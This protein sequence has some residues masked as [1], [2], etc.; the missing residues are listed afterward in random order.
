MDK[1]ESELRTSVQNKVKLDLYNAIKC[2][3]GAEKYLL[4]NIDKY[5]KSLLSQLRY[6]IF[7][8]QIET[9][10][11]TNEHREERVCTLCASNTIESVEHFLFECEAYALN[12]LVTMHCSS[13]K[14]PKLGIGIFEKQIMGITCLG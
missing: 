2:S 13:Q 5:E 3:Y 12:P 4:L 10:R 1:I 14:C 7:A 9:G 6:G 8:I 11:F